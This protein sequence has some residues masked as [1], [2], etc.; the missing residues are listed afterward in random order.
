MNVRSIMSAFILAA[1]SSASFAIAQT[2]AAAP[3]AQTAPAPMPACDGSIVVV[4]LSD[5]KPGSM[6]KFQ[7]AV[8]AHQAWYRNN[9]I[10]TNRIFMSRIIVRNPDTKQFAYSDTQV[11]TYHIN[12]PSSTSIPRG[13]AAWNAYVQM[14]RDSS[15]LKSEYV[16]CMPKGG[17]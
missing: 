12:P 11:I 7:A 6:D 10:S 5:V 1:L 4:R 8:A 9:G 13:D 3:S 17:Y 14:Y 2:P 16:T 15:D